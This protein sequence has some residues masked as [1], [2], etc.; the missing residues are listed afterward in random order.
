MEKS[1]KSCSFSLLPQSTVP[2]FSLLEG[3]IHHGENSYS[4]VASWGIS[5]SPE[6]GRLSVWAHFNFQLVWSLQTRYF[7]LMYSW[8]IFGILKTRFRFRHISSLP[9]V[10]GLSRCPILWGTITMEHSWT[11]RCLTPGKFHDS[12]QCVVPSALPPFC[13]HLETRKSTQPEALIPSTK[14]YPI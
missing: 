4:T 7:I 3:V 2:A 12:L 14:S 9:A 5:V 10:L 13:A 6:G 11:G 1:R 8:W